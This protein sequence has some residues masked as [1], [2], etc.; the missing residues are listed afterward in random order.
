MRLP[1]IAPNQD[2]SIGVESGF[3]GFA[4]MRADGALMGPWNPWLHEPAVGSAM[5]GLT[6]ALSGGASTLPDP[7]RQVAIL[8]TGAHFHAAYEVYAHAAVAQRGGLDN[9]MV[10]TIAIEQRSKRGRRG[11]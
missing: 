9:A 10:V 2:M 8:V 1:L 7:C 11:S 6:K 5:W 4:A 3:R